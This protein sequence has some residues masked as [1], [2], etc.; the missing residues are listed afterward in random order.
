MPKSRSNPALVIRALLVGVALVAANVHAQAPAQRPIR[1]VVTFPPGGSTDIAARLVAQ[2][3]SES[4]RIAV[5]VE[6]RPGGNSVPGTD[7]VA[8]SAPD[9][10]TLLMATSAF[11]V[12]P[13]LL[14]TLPFNAVDDFTPVAFVATFANV[15]V[16]NPSLRATSVGELIELARRSPGTLNFASPGA[17][18]TSRL[19]GELLK[20]SAG[21][22]I[23]HVPY[24]GGAPALADLIGGRVQLMFANVS[25]VVQPIRAGQLRGLALTGKDRMAVLPG[26]PTVA[27]AGYPGLEVINWQGILAPARTP[28]DMVRRLNAEIRRAV[29]SPEVVERFQALGITPAEGSPEDLGVHIRAEIAK[30]AQVIRAGGIKPD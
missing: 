4:L 30:W 7:Y 19:A 16:V 3:L 23:V 11:G 26:V 27:D 12:I 13:S 8:K 9:G 20:Q 5:V 15:L 25:E 29:Q 2:R 14:G 22:D 6:N 1:L 17:G 18:S 10:S 24:K 21:I 28:V